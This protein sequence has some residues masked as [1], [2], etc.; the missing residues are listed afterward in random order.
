MVREQILAC[1]L[2][3]LW[4]PQKRNIFSLLCNYELISHD[5]SHFKSSCDQEP[6]LS[7]H[8]P[9]T[10]LHANLTLLHLFRYYQT[11]LLALLHVLGL[12][13]PPAAAALSSTPSLCLALFG[14]VLFYI[15]D[16]KA[17]KLA[18]RDGAR[19]QTSPLEQALSFVLCPAFSPPKQWLLL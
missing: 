17:H 4:K 16:A 12:L 9:K 15:L 18:S 6:L 13:D 8:T 19:S 5:G 1:I 2:C 3:F 10:S 11:P 7:C 14:P